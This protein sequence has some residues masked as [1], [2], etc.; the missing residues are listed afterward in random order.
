MAHLYWYL[1]ALLGTLLADE[2]AQDVAEYLLITGAV[3]LALVAGAVLIATSSPNLVN[4]ICDG[5]ESVL[6]EGGVV[7]VRLGCGTQ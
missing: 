2:R 7:T 4:A 3:S 6:G 5:M 1:R